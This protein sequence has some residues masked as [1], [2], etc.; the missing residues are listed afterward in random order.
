MILI[1]CS[2][3]GWD[4]LSRITPVKLSQ[5]KTLSLAKILG[6]INP[7]NLIEVPAFRT[8]SSLRNGPCNARFC[9]RAENDGGFIPTSGIP[10]SRGF[11]RGRNL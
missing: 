9:V 10:T 2:F 7:H 3:C 4:K 1:H 8:L 11:A 5:L 6:L